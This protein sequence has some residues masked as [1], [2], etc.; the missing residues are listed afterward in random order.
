MVEDNLAIEFVIDLAIIV[1][2]KFVMPLLTY[3]DASQNK[4]NREC[5]HSDV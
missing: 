5:T 1:P 2:I 4:E 3:G